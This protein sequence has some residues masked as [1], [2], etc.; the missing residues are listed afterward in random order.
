M[1]TIEVRLH[2]QSFFFYT[3]SILLF[4]EFSSLLHVLPAFNVANWP[5]HDLF[6]R[7]VEA[8]S[9]GIHFA[10]ASLPMSLL[11]FPTLFHGLA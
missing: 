9:E 5:L 3:Y 10:S 6:K 2:K 8:S 11:A 4:R 1:I 7:S